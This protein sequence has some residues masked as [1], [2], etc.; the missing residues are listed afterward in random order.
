[1]KLIRVDINIEDIDIPEVQREESIQN[2][3]I[4]FTED[5][6]KLIEELELNKNEV[7]S[8][9]FTTLSKIFSKCDIN[10]I[11]EQNK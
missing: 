5:T 9:L 1:M 8:M 2:I 7:S 3:A 11:E 4:G 6:Y 10:N